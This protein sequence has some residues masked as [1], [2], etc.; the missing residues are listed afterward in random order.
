[1]VKLREKKLN[2]KHVNI[3]LRYEFILV[4]SHS[5]IYSSKRESCVGVAKTEIWAK[6]R[7]WFNAKQAQSEHT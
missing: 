4:A 1:M 6:K 2:K 5:S 7:E 3:S